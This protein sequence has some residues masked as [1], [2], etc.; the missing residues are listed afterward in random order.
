MATRC[1]A[2]T[3]MIVALIAMLIFPLAF[4]ITGAASMN[5]MIQHEIRDLSSKETAEPAKRFTLPD[6]DGLPEPVRRYFLHVLPVGRQH[7][8]WVK[9]KSTGKFKLPFSDK[10]FRVTASEYLFASK[11]GLI[12]DAQFKDCP[13]LGAWVHIRDKYA[14]QKATMYGNLFS[15]LNIINEKNAEELNQ[16]MFLRFIG[17]LTMIPTALLPNDYLSWKPIDNHSAK[18]IVTDGSNSGH[19]IV[20]F[21]N[22]GEIVR[23][24][25][26]GRYD[27]LDGRYRKVKHIAYRSNYREISGVRV[28]L[29]FRVEKILPDGTREIFWHGT[30]EDV[31]FVETVQNS[32]G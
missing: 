26:D 10:Y 19:A 31:R 20:G 27:R 11:P 3:I 29:D 32:H 12:F 16:D 24:E 13:F 14:M 28:P 23:W 17:H 8:A 1:N 7:I 15:G 30:I 9:Y 22:A 5:N 21:N 25:T 4:L 2:K 18:L 6:L